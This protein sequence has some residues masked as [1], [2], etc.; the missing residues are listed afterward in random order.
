MATRELTSASGQN[1]FHL[2]PGKA[3]S[4]LLVIGTLL[5]IVFFFLS[6]NVGG[7]ALARVSETAEWMQHP[8]IQFFFGRYLPLHFWMIRALAAPLGDA[9]LAGRLL[10]LVFGI[11]SLWLVW[12]IALAV[13]DEEA[14][15]LSLFVFVFYSLHVAYSTTSS[16]EVPYLFF[17]LAGLAGFFIYRRTGLLW[18]LGLGGIGLSCA[19]GIRYEAWVVIFA[20]GLLLVISVLWSLFQREEKWQL[21][22]LVLFGVTAGAWPAFW[23][24]FVWSKTGRPFFFVSE[25]SASVKDQLVVAQRSMIYLLSLSPAVIVLTLSIFAIAG[26]LYALFLAL[27]EPPGREFAVVLAIFALVQLHTILSSSLLPLARYTLT[28]GTFLAVASGYGL[29]RMAKWLSPKAKNVFRL[30]V[31]ATIIVNPAVL[32]AMSEIHNPLSDKF[33]SVSPELRFPSQIRDVG[34]FL[35]ERLR[36]KDA[37]VLDNYNQDS[38]ILGAAAGL[39]LVPG[40]RVYVQFAQDCSGLLDYIKDVQPRYVIYADAPSG[41]L[42]ACMSV[43]GDPMQPTTIGSGNIRMSCVF[44]NKV[45]RIYEVEYS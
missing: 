34:L 45:Y 40:K 21:G 19:A 5:R 28:L 44:R 43:P 10:S 9:G 36:P 38:N 24:Y 23:M 41:T 18:P 14:A 11:V 8:G 32:L 39:P 1:Q 29:E 20:L 35:Q 13:Y 7:D 15:N 2:D 4:W 6:D 31:A 16:S 26:S 3:G 42:K 22:P 37:V 17:V 27:R 12:L 30:G 25:Q 33:A